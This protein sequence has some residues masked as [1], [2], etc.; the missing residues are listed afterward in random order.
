MVEFI[1][2]K[3]KYPINIEIQYDN[4]L[5]MEGFFNM[6]K[7]PSYCYKF[8]WLEAIVLLISENKS[9]ATYDEIINEMI[10]NAWYSVL[11]YHIHLSGIFGDGI[12]DNLE[13]AVIKLQRLSNLPNSASKIEIKNCIKIYDKELHT[14]KMALTHNVP[15]KALSGFANQGET[16]IDLN[17]SAGRMMEYYNYIDRT[18]IVL[19]YVFGKEQGLERT[20]T[21]HKDWI[22]LIQDNTV[23]ILGWIQHEKVKWLQS[24]NPEVPG[25]VYKLSL[26]EEKVRRLAN[27]HR[28]WDEILKQ[29]DIRDIFNDEPIKKGDYDVDHFIP[30]SFVMHDE[31]WDLMPM[32]SNLNSSKNNR[33]PKWEPFFVKFAQNQFVMYQMIH[34]DTKPGM[35]KLYEACY[36]D[37][38]HSIWANQELY[39]RGNTRAE[40]FNIMEKNMRPIYDSARRQG[41]EL[42]NR[43]NV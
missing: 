16:K 26:N 7:D 4:Q 2:A 35:R 6:L 12:K 38:L 36:R 28:L 21:F 40:F 29:E 10:A 14:E 13:K 42:W 30:R 18:S 25:L 34:D 43:E 9:V 20:L 31:L 37:N 27:V 3:T 41:Y 24:N 23:A 19:P 39:R 11:E 22:Q 32:D 1:S 33:L 15:F 17:S 5:Y 8:Y